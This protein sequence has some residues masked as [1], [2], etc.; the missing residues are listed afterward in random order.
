MDTNGESSKREEAP[1]ATHN[2]MR[3]LKRNLATG[4]NK[5]ENVTAKEKI[6]PRERIHATTGNPYEFGRP[7]VFDQM[8]SD[9][10][11]EE[12]APDAAIWNIYLEEAQDRD[13]ELVEGRQRS[14]DTLL[15]FAALFSA[16]L[17][18][19]LIESKDLL[20]QDPADASVALLLIIAQSQQRV[21][22]GL[23]APDEST[24]V[25]TMPDFTPSLSARWING[26]WFMSLGLSL[27]A[28]LIAMLGKEWLTTFQS[29]RPRSSRR[30][31]YIRQ[32]RLKGLEDWGALHIVALLPTLLHVSLLLFAV[33]LVIYL[34]ALDV[35]VA[36]VLSAVI[37]VTLTFYFVTSTLGAVYEF[38]PFVT[39]VSEYI[40]KAVAA[41]FKN[42][43]HDINTETL[44]ASIKDLQALIWL[45]KH[46]VDPIV[47][48]YAYQAIAGLHRSPYITL[49]TPRPV[50]NL[51]LNPISSDKHS[52]FDN[53]ITIGSLFLDVSGRFDEL[54]AGTLETG[55]SEPPVC[56]YINAM[57]AL[58][59]CAGD[60]V[61]LI[62]TNWP[63]LLGKIH[64]FWDSNLPWASM[65]GGSF[66]G[67]LIAEMDVIKLVAD[68][69]Q[70]L[71][72]NSE[73]S[74][75]G[76]VNVGLGLQESKKPGSVYQDQ[77]AIKIQSS[78]TKIDESRDNLLL[79]LTNRLAEWIHISL[80]LLQS[81]AKEETDIE[82]Y[83]LNGLLRAV[84]D[85]ASYLE[86]FDQILRSQNQKSVTFGQKTDQL[87][88]LK[89]LIFLLSRPTD[90]SIDSIARFVEI[91]KAYS[92]IAPIILDLKQ[93]KGDNVNDISHTFKSCLVNSNA[94][95]TRREILCISTRYMVLTMRHLCNFPEFSQ[96]GEIFKDALDLQ[97]Q[98]Q[99]E[100]TDA[101]TGP[102][103][104]I[105]HHIG[106]YIDILKFF[107]ESESNIQ[108]LY[109]LQ[110]APERL[111][112]IAT[113]PYYSWSKPA[114][115]SYIPPSCF[116]TLMLIFS[117]T[118][119]NA[120]G[121]QEYM[122]FVVAR[123]RGPNM[124]LCQLPPQVSPFTEPRPSIEYLQQL[125]HTPHGFSALVKAGSISDYPPIVAPGIANVTV[126]AANHD[127]TIEV[128]PVELMPP[129]VPAF[130]E[131]LSWTLPRLSSLDDKKLYHRFILAASV[132]LVVACED[133]ES[134]ARITTHPD[135]KTLL[136]ELR[137]NKD[138]CAEFVS[139]EE[140]K[141]LIDGLVLEESGV[142]ATEKGSTGDEEEDAARNM[143][144]GGDQSKM[145]VAQE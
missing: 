84:S 10:F 4:G 3:F 68:N 45:S 1:N 80:H 104:A 141:R 118:K 121:A 49:D 66:A 137:D 14:L 128:K 52:P 76:Q 114:N 143:G 82:P 144:N 13:R 119:F 21:E 65:S 138:T 11:G 57:I 53:D 75:E 111:C 106:D 124:M 63:D 7:R 129:A 62:M 47:V 72:S 39:E 131:A 41:L 28:A 77:H 115:G 24:Q 139:E 35:A 17:T 64:R 120:N 93:R 123:L 130:L 99:L 15:L 102:R 116:L 103:A 32:S 60:S 87:A 94:P 91:L 8:A 42:P 2:A 109:Q 38:C 12:L 56:R 145:N 71:A 86:L 83:L 26:I 108:Q 27:S 16:I 58:V 110:W 46:S 96:C 40:R 9:R 122:D 132:L 92:C 61:P 117:N 78:I 136:R 81:H 48:D 113:A 100:D 55:N 34:W 127:S 90:L 23:P 31:A 54:L 22:L 50:L 112:I 134:R 98:Y 36:S 33:G 79:R 19:F 88:S 44:G 67:V 126:I 101:Y 69:V 135:R 18:A 29:S 142:K 43:R 70:L 37:G 133:Q 140:W 95:T 107:G 74:Q 59:S 30:L 89:I 5:D 25:V 73:T 125:T 20:Q 85:G 6:G 97:Y 105:R 51:H